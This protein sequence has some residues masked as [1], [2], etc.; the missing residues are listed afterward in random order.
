MAIDKRLKRL[1][2]AALKQLFNRTGQ[3]ILLQMCIQSLPS[4]ALLYRHGNYISLNC[5]GH[6]L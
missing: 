6:L 4:N 2:P 5:V 3:N 1:E